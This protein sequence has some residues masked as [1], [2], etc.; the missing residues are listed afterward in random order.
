MNTDDSP[1]IIGSMF[2]Q[3]DD[4]LIDAE[5]GI[6][7]ES[8]VMERIEKT[9]RLSDEHG[10]PFIIDVEIPSIKS[11]K[12]IIQSVSKNTD[13]PFW[14]SSF[15]E[16]MRLKACEIALQEGLKERVY[17]STLNYMSGEDEFQAVSDMGVRPIIQIFNPEDPYPEGYY[18]KAEELMKM[19]QKTGVATE[20]AVLLPTVLDFGSIPI[21][22]ST[23]PTLKEKYS[24]PICIPSIG[25]VYKW[26]KDYAPN[27]RRLLLAATLTYTAR[28]HADIIHIG[29]MKRAFIAFPVMSLLRQ[30]EQRKAKFEHL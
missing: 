30:F 8:K 12:Q 7:D 27:T 11:A 14:I 4:L 18:T 16:E 21:A 2:Y 13:K 20:H 25:P 19:A 10:V 23:I 1:V 29:T 26:A 3:G 6:I 5:K 17:Y 22:L 15:N 28:L 24:L 9:R